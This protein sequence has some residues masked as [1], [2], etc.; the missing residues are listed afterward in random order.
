MRHATEFDRSFDVGTFD[1]DFLVLVALNRGNAYKKRPADGGDVREPEFWVLPA[2][3]AEQAAMGAASRRR[4][5]LRK[6][7]T[8][9]KD[10][11]GAWWL[12]REFIDG[13]P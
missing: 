13:P 7:G 8:S 10:Y 6:L 1:F 9:A 11:V 4:V 12:I 3:V 2:S 5:S